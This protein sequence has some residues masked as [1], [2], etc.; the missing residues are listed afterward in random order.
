[1]TSHKTF[2]VYVYYRPDG[3][4]FYVGKGSGRRANDLVKNRNN[5]FK[6]V[7][8]KYGKDNVRVEIFE[9]K[10]EQ[11][12]F[13][14]EISLIDNFK[15]LGFDLTNLTGGGEGPSGMVH[16]K[17]SRLKMS[18]MRKGVPH[19]KQ[20]SENIGKS[21]LGMKRPPLSEQ[22]LINRSKAQ[23][24][25]KHSEETKLKISK[26]LVGNKHALGLKR[27]PMS[28]EVKAKVSAAKKRVQYLG[29]KVY[30]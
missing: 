17:T 30:L 22:A 9:C 21:H 8:N 12:A 27:P 24:G 5:Y 25:R 3:S 7:V 14:K 6:N 23:I 29:I 28:D 4:P 19:S 2:Y 13:E 11:D 20:H 26:S 16:S 15:N 10:S 18:L 1:M